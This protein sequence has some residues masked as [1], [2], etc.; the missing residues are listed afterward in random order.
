ML[1]ENLMEA[2]PLDVPC[3]PKSG[4]NG[5]DVASSLLPNCNFFFKV[6]HVCLIENLMHL[7]SAQHQRVRNFN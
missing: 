6:V 4:V 5:S 1:I 7:D 3:S 2:Q